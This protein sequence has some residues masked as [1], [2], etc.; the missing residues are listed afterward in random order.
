MITLKKEL[1]IFANQGTITIPESLILSGL[2]YI[3]FTLILGPIENL[4]F[5]VLLENI[6]DVLKIGSFVLAIFSNNLF[7]IP[8]IIFAIELIIIIIENAVGFARKDFEKADVLSFILNLIIYA[9]FIF[10]LVFGAVKG[11]P[12]GG[13]SILA[14]IAFT[15]V[16]YGLG[17][18]V[19]TISNS[20]DVANGDDDD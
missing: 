9:A 18:I 13:F 1:K 19:N 14:L 10:V 6:I 4:S 3:V 11:L 12:F 2:V 20:I 8:L 17:A 16:D 15:I 5:L 7:Y